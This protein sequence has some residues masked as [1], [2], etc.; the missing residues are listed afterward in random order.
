MGARPMSSLRVGFAAALA[1]AL[2]AGS[3]AAEGL[4]EPDYAEVNAAIVEQHVLPR[5]EAL[6]EAAGALD[7]AAAA[8]CAKPDGDGLEELRRHYHHTMDAW[9]GIQHVQF[10]PIELF[11][12]GYRLY[13]WPRGQG[14]IAGAVDELLAARDESRF[15]DEA[16]RKASVATQG[17]PAMEQLLYSEARVFGASGE[18]LWRCRLLTAISANLRDMTVEIVADWQGGRVAFARSMAEP[19]PE[20][21]YF[22]SHKDGTLELFKSFYTGLQ[23][24]ADARLSPVVGQ[25]LETAR[26]RMAE[27][28]LSE[29]SLRNVVLSLE[30]LQAL[31]LGENDGPGLGVLVVESGSDAKL[32]PLMRRAFEK[33][34]ATARGIAPPLGEAVKDPARR[35]QVET[36]RTQATAMKQ[37]VETRMATV[38]GLGVGFNA[39]DGD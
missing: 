11:Q 16:F 5:Y 26:P 31:Y 7:T 24:I 19:E 14:R 38:L 27:T 32:D 8:H 36:L 4:G 22:G 34:L 37:I 15:A 9:M 20:T 28:R 6:A 17:L 10:G 29:R 30:A 33:T 35:T 21:G 2:C 13:F 25:S 12:R 3:T 39:L 18:A 1:M 23:L